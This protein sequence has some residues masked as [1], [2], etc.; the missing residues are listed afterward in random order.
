MR[1]TNFSKLR[2]VAKKINFHT[3]C[4]AEQNIIKV[5]VVFIP[6]HKG[7]ASRRGGEGR[8]VLLEFTD[9]EDKS[10]PVSVFFFQ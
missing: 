3:I 1:T 9:T 2:K 6:G 10:I 8:G 5:V 7:E 4:I